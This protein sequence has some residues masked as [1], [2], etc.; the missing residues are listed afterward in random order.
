MPFNADEMEK[1]KIIIIII[2]PHI[3]FVDCSVDYKHS[4]WIVTK[5]RNGRWWKNP[6]ND[7]NDDDDY[8]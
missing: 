6:T 7:C 5:N 1:R 2:R 8:P 3:V 4:N